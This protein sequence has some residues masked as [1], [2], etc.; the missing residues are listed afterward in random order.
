MK[1]IQSCQQSDD[2]RLVVTGRPRID[3]PLGIEWLSHLRQWDHLPVP[4]D[5]TGAQH[6]LKWWCDPLLR[7]HRLAVIMRIEQDRSVGMGRHEFPINDWRAALIFQ[8]F[9]GDAALPKSQ[10]DRF[11]VAPQVRRISR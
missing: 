5:W 1:R 4:L 10:G 9:H 7:I 3:S 6:W 11:G 8:Q 2:R